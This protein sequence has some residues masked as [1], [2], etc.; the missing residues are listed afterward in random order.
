VSTP[1]LILQLDSVAR[2]LR[3]DAPGGVGDLT[4]AAAVAQLGGANG[5]SLSLKAATL[6]ERVATARLLQGLWGAAFELEIAPD[7][8]LLSA[9]LALHPRRVML[10]DTQPGAPTDAEPLDLLTQSRA[11]AEAVAGL[12]ELGSKAVLRI[13]PDVDQVKA[14]HRLGAG[15]VC[16]HLGAYGL[17]AAAAEPLL[18]APGAPVSELASGVLLDAARL[19]R[20]LGVAISVG[21]DV[22]SETGPRVRGLSDVTAVYLG[23]AVVGKA[24]LV[25][26]ERALRETAVSVGL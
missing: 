24:V 10:S 9:A 20:K 5:F 25:G 2:L 15:A 13:P 18:A 4:A 23:R 8:E 21:G 14:A 6:G 19:A 12:E 7:R 22:S 3:I 26:L 1:R 17:D 11:V 16:F